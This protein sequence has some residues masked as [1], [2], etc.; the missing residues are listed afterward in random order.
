M[1][2]LKIGGLVFVLGVCIGAPAVAAIKIQIVRDRPVMDGVYVNGHGPYQFLIDTGTTLNH[3]DPKVAQSIGLSPTFRT[4]LLSSTG[5]TTAVGAGGV[6]VAVASLQA[7]G[8]VFLF[9]GLDLIAQHFP[10]V[11]GV[12]GE[13]FLSH[14]DYLLDLKRKEIDFGKREPDTTKLRAAFRTVSGRPVVTT[15]LG[16]L[17]LDSGVTWVTLF[18]V[19]APAA[20]HKMLT[21]TGSTR[22]GTVASELVIGGRILWRGDALAIPPSPETEAAGLLP[23]RLFKTVYVCNSE[24]Y[25][26]LY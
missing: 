20:T 14:F 6:H 4:E 26:I 7:D 15:S 23:V 12:L 24:G 19:S 17:V 9:A 8:Q 10:R 1:R 5:S 2:I 18:G 25:L 21:F 13:E 16:P 22:V 11:Q 3:L